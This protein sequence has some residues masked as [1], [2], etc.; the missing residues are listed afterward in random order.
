MVLGLDAEEHQ[1]RESPNGMHLA[2]SEAVTP[3]G[4]ETGYGLQCLDFAV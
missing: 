1:A 4:C 2:K 3:P